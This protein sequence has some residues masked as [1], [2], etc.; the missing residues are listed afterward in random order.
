MIYFART[1]KDKYTPYALQSDRVYDLS[2]S[3]V[4]IMPILRN[5]LTQPD[6]GN[7]IKTVLNY[8]VAFKYI[9]AIDYL[10]EINYE[11]FNAAVDAY[12]Q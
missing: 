11:P 7:D 5:N 1:E 10:G 3:S 8:F 4:E 2:L 9:P 6:I 12:V